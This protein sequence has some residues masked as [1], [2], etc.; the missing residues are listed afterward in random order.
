[1]SRRQDSDLEDL[2]DRE[3]ALEHYA[4]LL[5][6]A[7]LKAPLDP[8]FRPALR[9]RLMEAAY[10][11]YEAR[12]R[13]SIFSRLFSGPGMA[14]GLAAAAAILLVAVFIANGGNW[15]GA[16]PVQVTT[17][18]GQVAVNQ[19]ITVSFNQ[20]MDH[21][22]VEKA[23]QI[24]PATQVTYTWR[25]NSLAIAP[26]SGELAPN[27]QYRV[28]VAPE[29][30]TAPGVKI[31]QAQMV[32]VNTAPL[33]A[34]S[35]T[36][37]PSPSPPA[38]PQITA[39][40]SLPGTGG[41]T[42]GWTPD[43][44][45]IIFI[46][47][48]DLKSINADGTGVKTI[49][50]GVKLASLAPSG[51]SLVY[52]TTG[53]A[54]KVV[55]ASLDGSGGQTLDSRDVSAIGWQ[56][57]KLMVV[58]G[59]DVGPAGVAPAARLPNPA[60]CKFSPDGTKVICARTSQE[61]GTGPVVVTSFV[62]E[63]ATQKVTAWP[64]GGQGFAWSPD[65]SRVAYWRGGTTYI[66]SPDGSPGTAIGPSTV[67]VSL[68]WSPDGK[69][70]LLAGSD[71]ASIVKADGSGL[72]QLSQSSF[73]DPVWSPGGGKFAYGRGTSLWLDD[74]AVS[75]GAIDLG[76]AGRIIDQ[77]E[78][79]R[80]RNDL[81]TASQFL[82]PGATPT[83]PSPLATDLHLARYFVISSQASAGDVRC[84]VRLIFSRGNQETRYQ[85][86]QLVLVPAGDVLKISSITDSPV[87]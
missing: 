7:R 17:V 18:G 70:L 6:S 76:A 84:T 54:H 40:H 63:I 58:S 71:G 43:G 59:T 28:T 29:A 86:E 80:I 5:R 82:A 2:F 39:E 87:H 85:D 52:V 66:G 14:M 50:T 61:T 44:K 38:P 30:K 81:A 72:H 74:L 36:P 48:E 13:P 51:T 57:G 12:R 83:S 34:P 53:S 16:G 11:R 9:R 25:G 42:V 68:S 62:L 8:N 75:G 55:G 24:E 56:N 47:G 1:M 37:S 20:P 21:Q 35:A 10:E 22:S 3:P 65:S 79:A 46:D 26:T 67:P 41:K 31:G 73:H 15:F 78:L 64:T 32:A 69:L 33:P 4:N 49:V 23:I 45:V 77:Y 19:P 60:D 27:T